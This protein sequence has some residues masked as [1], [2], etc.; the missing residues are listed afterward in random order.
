[1]STEETTSNSSS[2]KNDVFKISEEYQRIKNVSKIATSLE[3]KDVD[4]SDILENLRLELKTVPQD[5]QAIIKSK[6]IGIILASLCGDA[7][8]SN[9]EFK[10]MSD[11]QKTF[12]YVRDFK[13]SS[14]RPRGQFTDDGES[15]LA[16]ATGIVECGKTDELDVNTI[17]RHYTTAFASEPRRGYGPTSSRILQMLASGQTTPDKSGRLF[18]EDGSYSNGCLMRIAPLGLFSFIRDFNVD[19]VKKNVLIAIE[20]T[21]CHVESIEVCNTYCLLM[22]ELLKNSFETDNKNDFVKKVFSFINSIVENDYFKSK[23]SIVEQNIDKLLKINAEF[24]EKFSIN[25]KSEDCAEERKKIQSE[26]AKVFEKIISKCPFGELFAIRASEAFSVSLYA[27]F[28][29]KIIGAEESLIRVVNWG[30][31]ADTI[32]CIVG[33]LLGAEYGFQF[34]PKRWVNSVEGRDLA[35]DTA[36]KIIELKH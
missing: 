27:L 22:I 23:L 9:T 20:C 5:K 30:G 3:N 26:E 28:L 29:S 8:G 6:A 11:I 32:A 4:D 18:F 7:L 19:Q 2:K 33:G 25:D 1:M 14:W 35:I 13:H 31:D 15:L 21:H 36:L 24:A 34:L 16:L 17:V 10:S 12:G